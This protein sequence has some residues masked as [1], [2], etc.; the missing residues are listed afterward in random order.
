[1]KKL[2]VAAL[3]TCMVSIAGCGQ[4]SAS[5]TATASTS[6]NQAS[7]SVESSKS[8]EVSETQ[9]PETPTPTDAPYL[10]AVETANQVKIGM[11]YDQVKEIFGSDGE[12]LSQYEND[13]VKDIS[14]EWSISDYNNITVTFENDAAIDIWIY[15]QFLTE[16]EI[17]LDQFNQVQNGMTYEQVRDIMGCEGVRTHESNY[18]NEKDIDYSWYG[19]ASYNYC[20][21]SFVNGSVVTKTQS[22]LQ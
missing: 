3:I 9:T 19:Y 13:G 8:S 22:S 7:V 14:C 6:G 16:K 18:L 10:K 21:I 12:V 2:F 1:M 4:S 5:S 15:G 20:T 11:N 17:T